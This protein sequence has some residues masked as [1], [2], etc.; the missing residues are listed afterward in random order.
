[1][2][3]I[4]AS[5][6]RIIA[7]D[8]TLPSAR[9]GSRPKFPQKPEAV[10]DVPAE[11]PADLRAVEDIESQEVKL[12]PTIQVEGLSPAKGLAAAEAPPAQTYKPVEALKPVDALKALKEKALGEKDAASNKEEPKAPAEPLKPAERRNEPP[13]RV[14]R[15]APAAFRS[16]AADHAAE[17]RATQPAFVVEKGPVPRAD[18]LRPTLKLADAQASVSAPAEVVAATAETA[19]PASA[20]NPAAGET[21]LVSA[22][23]D[24]AVNAAFNAL[25]ASRFVQESDAMMQMAREIMR[26]MLKAWLDDNLPVMVERLVRAEIER[27]ARGGR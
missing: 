25:I 27:A 13:F 14:A 16:A 21:P 19:H 22:T 3:E 17:A 4:L 12:E 7:D 26:P 9:S 11:T 6:R 24:A 20:P 8:Q 5:I 2:E 15:T 23:T 18:V 1:M 10:E